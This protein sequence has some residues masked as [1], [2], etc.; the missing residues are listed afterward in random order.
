VLFVGTKRQAQD[1]I[2]EIA[3]KTDMPYVNERWLGGMLTNFETV[4]KSVTKLERLEKMEEEGT[5]QFLTKK[6]VMQIRKKRE[7][8]NYVL[9]GVRKNETVSSGD[10]HH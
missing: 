10:F 1:I 2:R 4:R 9:S 8:L 3:Q 7:K 5:Y 6:E